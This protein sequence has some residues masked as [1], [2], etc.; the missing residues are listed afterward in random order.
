[1]E[2]A[3]D[4]IFAIDRLPANGAVIVAHSAEARARIQRQ[5]IAELGS[6]AAGRTK[7][8]VV[9][10]RLAVEERMTGLR[11]RVL[12]DEA[13][14]ASAPLSTLDLVLKAARGTNAKF[15]KS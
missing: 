10:D 3:Q 9:R 5:I 12:L 14:P 15:G 2:I 7:V 6:E 13:F 8:V 1:M 11:K 4:E